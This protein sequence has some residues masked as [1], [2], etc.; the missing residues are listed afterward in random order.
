MQTAVQTITPC[1][2]QDCLSGATHNKSDG[3]QNLINASQYLQALAEIERY[4]EDEAIYSSYIKCNCSKCHGKLVHK[5][6]YQRHQYREEAIK[7]ETQTQN[8][9]QA[10]PIPT[11]QNIV[12]HSAYHYNLPPPHEPQNIPAS[13][14]IQYPQLYNPVFYSGQ[15][16]NQMQQYYPEHYLWDQFQNYS[17][18]NRT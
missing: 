5:R 6:T 4:T 12:Y 15:T 11:Q 18:N 10:T 8:I 14:N 7:A 16:Q 1:Q 9:Y 13:Q 3:I 2:C 17:P